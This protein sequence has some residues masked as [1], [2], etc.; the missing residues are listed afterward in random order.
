LAVDDN[1]QNMLR[2]FSIEI[3]ADPMLAGFAAALADRD[4]LA[5]CSRETYLE[6]VG[7]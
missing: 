1:S 7:H 4:N 3:A 2:L 6:R 5:T